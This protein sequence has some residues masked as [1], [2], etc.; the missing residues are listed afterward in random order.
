MTTQVQSKTD[1]KDE[2]PCENPFGNIIEIYEDR[3]IKK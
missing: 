1:E 2:N 3:C